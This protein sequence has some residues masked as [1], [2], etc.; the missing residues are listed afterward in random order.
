MTENTEL[1]PYQQMLEAG[2]H[3]G[4]KRTVFNPAMGDNVYAVRDGICIIDLPK[5]QESIATTIEFL[6]SVLAV[7]GMV[8]WVAPTKQ[9]QDGIKKLADQTGMPYVLDRWLGG[10]LTNFKNL[11]G[12]VKRLIELEEERDAGGWMKYTKKEQL[13]LTREVQDMQ[14]KF[15]GLKKLTRI[16]DAIFVSSL[17]EGELAVHEAKLTGVKVAAIA[18]TDADPTGVTKVIC[19]NDRSKRSVDLVLEAIAKNLQKPIVTG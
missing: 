6:N 1:I 7:G 19:A 12:R 9:S 5:T 14:K 3:F 17:K 10:T 18:N 13:E 16:P 2:M 15:D 8:L 4:R 11:N